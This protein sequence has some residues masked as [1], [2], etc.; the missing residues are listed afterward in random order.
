MIE[1]NSEFEA[2]LD[3]VHIAN[4]CIAN[5]LHTPI[6]SP[7]QNEKHRNKH[8]LIRF[9]KQI[10]FGTYGLIHEANVK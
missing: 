3:T 9:R 1:M 6:I 10:K 5:I 8:D 2:R 4:I 7:S